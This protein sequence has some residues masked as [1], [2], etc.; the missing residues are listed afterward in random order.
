[1]IGPWGSLTDVRSSYIGNDGSVVASKSR[2]HHEHT[3]MY[4]YRLSVPLPFTQ[5]VT[6]SVGSKARGSITSKPKHGLSPNF[7]SL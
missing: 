2:E 3:R 4:E 1:M 6:L 5:V 7:T